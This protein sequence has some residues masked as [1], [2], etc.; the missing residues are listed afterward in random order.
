MHAIKPLLILQ[1]VKY[2]ASNLYL[3][4]GQQ[5]KG[6]WPTFTFIYCSISIKKLYKFHFNSSV[7]CRIISEDC[8]TTSICHKDFQWG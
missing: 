2:T 6:C 4:V 8:C 5:G 7:S 3:V 1:K